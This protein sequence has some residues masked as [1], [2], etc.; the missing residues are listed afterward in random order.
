MTLH[1]LRHRYPE[2]ICICCPHLR[3]VKSCRVV[4]WLCLTAVDDI[5]AAREA[6]ERLDLDGVT[7]A[8]AIS[9]AKSI[10]IE[11]TLAARYFRV[12]LGLG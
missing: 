3:D 1:D 6:L 5:E 12:Y 10:T 8:V 4:S 7:D 2:K 11:G 9:T